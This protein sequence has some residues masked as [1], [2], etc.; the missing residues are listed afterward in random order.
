MKNALLVLCWF[1]CIGLNAQTVA[2]KNVNVIPMDGD[3]V[4]SLQTVLVENG[5]ITQ[6]GEAAE[7]KIPRQAKIIDGTGKYLMPGLMDMHVHFFTEQGIASKFMP[8]ETK[9]MLA[10]GVTTARIMCGDSQYLALKKQLDQGRIPGPEL[11]VVSPQLVGKWP[12]RGPFF[13]VIADTPEKARAAVREFKAQGYAALKITFFVQPDVY[14]AAVET[15]R[16]EGLPVTGHVG[17]DVGLDR[18]LAAGQQIEHL[19]EFLEQ[20]LPDTVK[21]RISVSGT[22]VWDKKKAWPTV[23][24]LDVSKIPALVQRIKKAGISVTPT[25]YFLH[26]SFGYGQ[27]EDSIRALPDFD[28]IPAS[29]KPDRFKAREYFWT[30]PP[31]EALRKRYI[32]LRQHLTRALYTAGVPLLCGSDSP[33]WFLVSGFS[34]HNELQA[35]VE[36][37]LPPF[38]ALETATVNPARY[39]GVDEQKGTIAVGKTADLLLLTANPLDDIANS[40]QIEGVF[41]Q[42]KYYDR[43][44]LDKLLKEARVLGKQ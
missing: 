4:R 7:I 43:K 14:D 36:A 31:P 18:A 9:I 30:D 38:A 44:T 10:N 26:S 35:M 27:H 25:H 19:D 12:F 5:V 40:R 24:L 6:M 23:D 16:A 2:F 15:A 22:S 41:H 3:Y 39:L 1:C 29:L 37:G 32:S 11:V 13:G 8:Q 42:G 21:Q 17:P 34:V 33:E 28:Y 20:L